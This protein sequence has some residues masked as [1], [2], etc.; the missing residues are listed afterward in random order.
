MINIIIEKIVTDRRQRDA[1][2]DF[3]STFGI[4]V[5]T[6]VQNFH[7]LNR[8]K[9]IEKTFNNLSMQYDQLSNEKDELQ[10]EV[11]KLRILPSQME[12]EAQVQRNAN[13]KKENDSL[14]EVLKTSKE[15]IAMLQGRLADT[16]EAKK[17]TKKRSILQQHTQE[18]PE[19]RSSHITMADF[20]ENTRRKSIDVN[21]SKSMDLGERK[22]FDI[23][24]RR[25]MDVRVRAIITSTTE[26][27]TLFFFG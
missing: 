9:G 2:D 14:R 22:L 27:L 21:H 3:S 18:L 4:A 13:L 24:E 12:Y 19:T 16:Q 7:D 6:I 25:S 20:N 5:G 26:R 17:V 1:T 10:N 15:T 11:Q 23:K 8:L